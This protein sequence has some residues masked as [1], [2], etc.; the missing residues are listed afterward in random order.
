MPIGPA[1]SWHPKGHFVAVPV[2]D[3]PGS[4]SV[5]AVTLGRGPHLVLLHGFVQASWA[6]RHNLDALA[7]RFT[8]HALCVPGFGWSAKPPRA[9]FRLLLQARRVL[10]WLDRMGIEQTHLV[11]NS[12]G[13][14]LA[15]QL[16]ALS[17]DRVDRL[18][19]VNPAGAGAYP[20]SQLARLQTRAWAPLLALPGIPFG[21]KLGLRYGAYAQLP[22]D[23]AYMAHFLAPLG[24]RG[25]GRAA[26]DAARHFNR[27]LADLD[28]R[29]RGVLHPTL[30]IRGGRDRVIPERVTWRVANRLHDARVEAFAAS[31]H[32]PMEEEPDRF[33]N[34]VLDH[35]GASPAAT[36]AGRPPA[37]SRRLGRADPDGLGAGQSAATRTSREG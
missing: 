33:N 19:L 32:C 2:G 30:V 35:L 13:G 8:V 20:M 4:L 16:A 25:A 11:G 36:P 1:L 5:H 26:L 15:L 21:L 3:G 12:L 9:S 29:L 23:D 10:A 24:T 27:D 18:V 34:A 7:E 22:I 37:R 31:G 6:W 14:A 17:P 28:R